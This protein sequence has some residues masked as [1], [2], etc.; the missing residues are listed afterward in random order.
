MPVTPSRLW[1]LRRWTRDLGGGKYAPRQPVAARIFLCLL[2]VGQALDVRQVSLQ[3]SPTELRLGRAGT[4]G[5]ERS[6][7]RIAMHCKAFTI[8]HAAYIDDTLP[9][10]EMS[11]MRDH[12]TECAKCASRDSEVRRA[13]ML[14]KNLPPI[15]DSENF[16]D[17]LRARLAA[18]STT[19]VVVP[20]P[21]AQAGAVKWAV[22]AGLLIVVA[23]GITSLPSSSVEAPTRLPAVIAMGP[24]ITIGDDSAPAYVAS[25]STGIPMWPA[26]MLAEEGPLRFANTGL[27]AVSVDVRPN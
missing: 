22:A 18:E 12:L 8:R 26:L 2:V 19:P 7:S 3:H 5:P 16:Q 27:H 20:Q 23:G 11:A 9:G 15:T 21:R 10:V 1:W 24:E 6:H 14:V 13:L 4:V 25:M 17:R